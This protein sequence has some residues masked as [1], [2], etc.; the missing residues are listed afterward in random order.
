MDLV[1]L[2]LLIPIFS[3]GLVPAQPINIPAISPNQSMPVAL[4]CNTNGLVQKMDPLT[5]LQV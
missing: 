5:N 3:F 1:W 2:A 4:T